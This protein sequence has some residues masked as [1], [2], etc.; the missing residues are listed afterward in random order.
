MCGRDPAK[1]TGTN[2]IEAYSS[3]ARLAALLRAGGATGARLG[4]EFRGA[5]DAQSLPGAHL[6]WRVSSTWTKS[7]HRTTSSASRSDGSHPRAGSSFSASGCLS[8]RASRGGRDQSPGSLP[9]GGPATGLVASRALKPELVRKRF[10][11]SFP[12]PRPT[13]RL[14][15][16]EAPL[17]TSAGDR[18]S[19][20][21]EGQATRLEL[22]FEP[23]LGIAH[24]TGYCRAT[25][26][27]FRHARHGDCWPATKHL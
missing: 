20:I 11:Y 18:P 7:P 4:T 6:R 5:V 3:A 17:G 15:P 19:V 13:V 27:L 26:V 9:D 16:A 25:A 2:R 12:R 8:S 21:G 1:E 14:D 24:F 23:E 22:W 10:R